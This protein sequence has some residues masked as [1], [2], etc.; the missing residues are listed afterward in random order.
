MG[1]KLA[2]VALESV[3]L[4]ELDVGPQKG[5]LFPVFHVFAFR[6]QNSNESV[7]YV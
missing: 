6:H 4:L 3:G 7:D 1:D 5:D 2:H